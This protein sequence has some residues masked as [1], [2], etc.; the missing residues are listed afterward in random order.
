LRTGFGARKV[1]SGL[2]LF[3]SELTMGC[4]ARLVLAALLAALLALSPP[5][6]QA[7]NNVAPAI[8][9][10]LIGLG[11]GAAIAGSTPPPPNGYYQRPPPAAYYPPPAGYYAPPPRYY[12]P[13]PP[14]VYYGR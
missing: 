8:I 12:A 1:A 13:P 2:P 5:P 4:R 11:I 10:G 14:P 7:R 9:G 6:A 3:H